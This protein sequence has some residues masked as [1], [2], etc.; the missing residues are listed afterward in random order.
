MKIAKVFALVWEAAAGIRVVEN[1]GKGVTSVAPGD[2][3]FSC[4]HAECRECKFCTSGK[5]NLCSKV[6]AATSADVMLAD[7]RSRFMCQ[8]QPLYH[9]MGTSTFSEYTTVHD[10]SVAKTRRR[11][12]TRTMAGLGAVLNTAKVEKGATMAVFG[13]GIVG[14]AG[15]KLAGA[16]QVI[17]VDVDTNKYALAAKFGATEFVNPKDHSEP[18]QEEIKTR[19]FQLVMGRTWKGTA[20]GGYKSRTTRP[21]AR[22]EVLEQAAIVSEVLLWS[23]CQ[24]MKLVH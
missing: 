21:R 24:T 10:L 9:F 8:G 4:Y 7:R 6:H 1:V 17:G 22:Q 5:S 12:S 13:L 11:P 2:H 19:S 23:L 14:L 18:I 3:V 20:F 16:S 15:A